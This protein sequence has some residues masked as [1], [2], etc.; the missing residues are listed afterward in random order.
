MIA[1]LVLVLLLG[2]IDGQTCGVDPSVCK[3]DEKCLYQ[4]GVNACM[5][6]LFSENTTY[7]LDNATI[8]YFYWVIEKSHTKVTIRMLN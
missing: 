2:F 4:D 3:E 1:V 5:R 8:N 6:Q 7:T